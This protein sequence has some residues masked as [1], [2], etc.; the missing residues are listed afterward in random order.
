MVTTTTKFNVVTAVEP[1]KPKLDNLK[2]T[3]AEV[4]AGSSFT[5][6]YRIT[7]EGKGPMTGMSTIKFT[8]PGPICIPERRIPS[9]PIPAGGSTIES[10]PMT[11]PAAAIAGNYSLIVTYDLTGIPGKPG[12]PAF[13]KPPD[14]QATARGTIR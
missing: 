10:A 14:V 2:I 12:I 8:C 1:G 4:K 11:M 7:N 6:S 5:V 9:K 3:P 13:P